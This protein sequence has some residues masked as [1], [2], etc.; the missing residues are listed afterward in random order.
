MRATWTLPLLLV[1]LTAPA[2]ETPRQP[3]PA[4][5]VSFTLMAQ[6]F[7]WQEFDAHGERLLKESGSLFGLNAG[8]KEYGRRLGVNLS[9]SVFGGRVDYDGQTQSGVPATTRT[10]Y[11]GFDGHGDLLERITPATHLTLEAFAGL[12]AR[13]WQR[14]LQDQGDLQGYSE[15]WTSGYG[16][17]GVGA[18]YAVTR[19]WQLFAQAG[20]RLPLTTIENVDLSKAGVGHI[21]LH[22]R[23]Q[24]APFAEMG[25]RW[26]LLLLSFFY[27]TLRFD[28]SDIETITGIERAGINRLE[29]W[30]PES[31]ADIYGLRLGFAGDF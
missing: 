11:A 22:P 2:A 5:D 18:A 8:Y 29:F 20:L 31:R 19:E 13:L 14:D 24:L 1:A 28:K 3:P 30:Q 26:K 6:Q 27:E 9:A 16:R 23:Q 17:A 4:A 12:G 10:I 15:A 25:C 7:A 21:T